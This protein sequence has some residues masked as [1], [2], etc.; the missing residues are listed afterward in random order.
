MDLVIGRP[1]WLPVLIQNPS[2][3]QGITGISYDTDGLEVKAAPAGYE[4]QCVELS[5]DSWIEFGKGIYTFLCP[6]SLIS[7]IGTFIYAC[8]YPESLDY[9]GS[10]TVLPDIDSDLL[11]L[12]AK[13]SAEQITVISPVTKTGSIALTRGA[14]YLQLDGRAISFPGAGSGWPTLAE[15]ALEF[16]VFGP[17]SAADYLSFACELS[18]DGLTPVLELTRDQ[19][20]TMPEQFTGIPARYELWAT[21]QSG[22]HV[23]LCKGALYIEG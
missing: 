15:S 23:Q 13:L 10:V 21:L 2:T 3:F 16:R 18:P 6:A 14:D 9:Q 4:G 12:S 8:S 7:E 1:A 19:I 5:A 22:S 17:K 11:N 20:A